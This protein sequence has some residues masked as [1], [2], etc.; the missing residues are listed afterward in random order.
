MRSMKLLTVFA[1]VALI[2]FSGCERKVTEE[3]VKTVAADD[4]AYIGSGACQ[5]CHADLYASFEKTGH[6]YKLNDASDAFTPGY[7]PFT[8]LPTTSPG[9]D[10]SQAFMVIGGFRWKARFIDS[11]GYI[12]TGDQVQYNF[13]NDSWTAY[14]S[15]ETKAYDCGPCHMTAYKDVGNQDDKEGLVGTWEFNGIQCEECHGPG[16]IH[17]GDPYNIAMKVDRSNEG[18]GKCHIRG[19]EEKIPASGGFVKHHEQWNEMFQSKHAALKCISCHNVHESL[20]PLNPNKAAAI[21]VD[22][23]SCHSDEATSFANSGID[24]AG[25]AFGPSCVDCH[26]PKAAK[27]AVASGEFVGDVRSH[28]FGINTAADAEMFTEDGSYAVGNLTV[29]YMCLQCHTDES[30]AWAS[31]NADRIHGGEV[32]SIDDCFTCH[33]DNSF[34]LVVAAIQEE[35]SYSVHASGDNTDR[36]RLSAS[37]YAACEKCHTNEGFLAEVTGIPASGEHFTS[38]NCFTCHAPHTDGNFSV[39]VTAPVVLANGTT[40]DRGN[41]NLCVSCHQSRQDVDTYVVDN[42]TLSS[43]WGPHHSTQGDMLIGSNAY[44]YASY[45]YSSSAHSAVATDGCVD[46]HMSPAKHSSIGG[47]SWNMHNESRDFKNLDGCNSDGCH[48]SPLPTITTFDNPSTGDYDWDG[49]TEGIQTEINGLLDSLNTHLI[50]A[51]LI[52]ING[53]PISV[54]VPNAD[55]AGALYNYLFVEDDRSEGI[56]NTAYAVGLLQ[57]SINYL[58]SGNPNGTPAVNSE[59]L[60]SHK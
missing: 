58:N 21:K 8:T 49:L 42:V 7:Y 20:H 23:E 60:S 28:M 31:E 12:M 26:M 18:C 22:C 9:L 53:T 3:V 43:H 19:T 54:T 24:H 14:H 35:Y 10:L 5:A 57:S 15:G 32:T 16:E 47:H 51:G 36:N 50:A 4:A 30:K 37:Y 29:E 13:E 2:I 40:F 25:S 27:S 46:C 34:G 33:N 52:D 6:P 59:L 45:S 39:R 55:S 56:H 11:S 17:A 1:L 44:E 48:T 41:A 38:I